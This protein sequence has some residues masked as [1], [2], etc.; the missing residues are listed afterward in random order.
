M[1]ISPLLFSVIFL[2]SATPENKAAKYIL[3][4]EL[5]I[6]KQRLL[7]IEEEMNQLRRQSRT[8]QR[9]VSIT[10]ADQLRQNN[11]EIQS[12]SEL[13]QMQR[14]REA[15]IDRSADAYLSQITTASRANQEQL[16]YSL[17]DIERERR[18]IQEQ[19]SFTTQFPVSATM[20][21]N[22]GRKALENRFNELGLQ[23]ANLREQR[24]RLSALNLEQIQILN[25]DRVFQKN[26]LYED[27]GTLQDS[28]S[29]LRS[30]N[31]R[32][33]ASRVQAELNLRSVEQQLTQQQKNFQEQQQK[34]Q[35]LVR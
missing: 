21:G 29:A 2:V 6:E 32:L 9:E 8:L 11:N 14:S 28:I 33:E 15:A 31:S 24:Q 7:S 19:I 5:N 23:L 25:N 1:R 20:T 27:L 16:E 18:Q 34:I 35:K 3:Q 4:D 17:Q 12:L 26:Q 13:L 30:E 10:T 22:P